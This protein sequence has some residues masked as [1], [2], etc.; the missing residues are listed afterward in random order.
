MFLVAL[1]LFRRTS[2]EDIYPNSNTKLN[3]IFQYTPILPEIVLPPVRQN[4]DSS[5]DDSNKWS[6]CQNGMY[7]DDKI[8]N[9]FCNEYQFLSNFYPSKL[10]KNGLTFD[11]VEAAYQASKFDIKFQKLFTNLSP[12]DSK[13]LSKSLDYDQKAFSKI[14]VEVMWQL[15]VAKF[16]DPTMKQKLK[17]TGNRQLVEFNTWGDTFWGQCFENGEITGRNTLGKLLMDIRSIP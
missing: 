16:S 5:R 4:N 13:M 3:T 14:S 8:I 7:A 6:I 10:I 2:K 9:G 17:A 11:S 15:L 12:D 1:I